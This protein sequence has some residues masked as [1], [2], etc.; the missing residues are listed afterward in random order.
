MEAVLV[1]E[2]KRSRETYQMETELKG[3]QSDDED[4]IDQIKSHISN[5]L[6]DTRRGHFDYVMELSNSAGISN[7][8]LL[9]QECRRV[10]LTRWCCLTELCMLYETRF[11]QHHSDQSTFCSQHTSIIWHPLELTVA[12]V[13]FLRVAFHLSGIH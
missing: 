3:A 1:S 12:F 2:E 11:M 7:N 6:P 4:Q 5:T 13:G 8:S 9:I 10:S